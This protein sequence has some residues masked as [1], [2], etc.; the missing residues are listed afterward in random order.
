MH[1]LSKYYGLAPRGFTPAALEACQN[2][3]WP[4]NLKQLE[5]FVKCYLI[6]GDEELSLSEL[7]SGPAKDRD[8]SKGH[9]LGKAFEDLEVSTG[10]A[11][12]KS[13]KSMIRSVRWETERSAIA[14]ALGK[15]GWNRK[16]AAR[17]LGVS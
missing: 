8:R 1:K 3:S 17:M 10:E 2:H 11:P 16:A 6:A 15:T 4:G 14:A 9:L 13:L 7:E 12:P 5:T